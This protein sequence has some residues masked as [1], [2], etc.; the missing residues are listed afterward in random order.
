MNKKNSYY[1]LTKGDST[2]SARENKQIDAFFLKKKGIHTS[3]RQ[4]QTQCLRP[5][6][7]DVQILKSTLHSD[8]I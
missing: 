6:Q 4:R 3:N 8:F 1:Q 2:L 5:G 7:N